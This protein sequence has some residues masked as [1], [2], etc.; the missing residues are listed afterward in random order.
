MVV[1]D[2]RDIRD[3]CERILS[4]MGLK[5][6]KAV[7][8]E[9]G[10]AVL[11]KEPV[12]IVLLDLKMPGLDGL[13]VLRRIKETYP[14]TLVIV[15]TGYATLETAVEAMQL[16]AYDFLSKPFQPNHLRLTVDRTIE[17]KRLIEEAKRLELERQKTL[18]DLDAE[19]SRTRTIIRALPNGVAVTTPDGRLAMMNPAF[20]E[21]AGLDRGTKPGRH[22]SAYVEDEALCSLVQTTSK[23]EDG[24]AD[25]THSYEF[26]APSGQ[27]LLATCTQVRSNEGECLGAVMVLM[28]V[29][30]WKVLDKLKNEFLAKVSHELRSPLSTIQ[31]QLDLALGDSQAEENQKGRHLVSRA[32]E[33]TQGLITLIRDLLDISRIEWGTEHKELAR[34]DLAET[35][36]NVA[37][38]FALQVQ[39]RRH[40][41]TLNLPDEGLP[42][43]KG[44]PTA[45]ESVFSNLI[46][47]AINYTPDGGRIV[48]EASFKDGF[49]QVD[50]KDDGFGIKAE[51]LVNIFEKFY[52]VKN[53]QTRY[54]TGTGLGLPIVSSIVEGMGGKIN[55]ESQHDKGSTFSVFL[56][57]GEEER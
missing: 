55:V 36:K 32:K 42:S 10:L 6:L 5:V 33:R 28:D 51:Y 53:E 48:V 15:I 34:L 2:E 52:R 49:I 47:N 57:L 44:D 13:E 30:D 46:A 3:G 40:S 35:L 39:A 50:V 23:G 14:D 25:E 29:T 9:S 31:L 1:D 56:P 37:D 22:I 7:D 38:S 8:G 16:G 21:M 27:Y 18:V 17:R 12:S 54:V 20:R 19:K 43:L 45:L 11:K 4:R 41:L 26:A 24:G